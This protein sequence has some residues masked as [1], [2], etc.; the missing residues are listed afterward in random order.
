LTHKYGY[1]PDAAE[2][3]V[4]YIQDNRKEL[5]I[6]ATYYTDEKTRKAFPE[7]REGLRQK[8]GADLKPGFGQM[9][10]TAQVQASNRLKAVAQQDIVVAFQLMARS[11]PVTKVAL[12]GQRRIRQVLVGLG[13]SV[14]ITNTRA[15]YDMEFRNDDKVYH[16]VGWHGTGIY[17]HEKSVL[18]F[19]DESV[20]KTRP[21]VTIGIINEDNVTP[22]NQERVVSDILEY[23]KENE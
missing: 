23:I 18:E 10:V 21:V 17:G 13:F 3:A 2:A 19:I 14:T 8:V 6:P 11:T 12:E 9:P 20:S 15:F 22:A 1:T 16:L 4:K 5:G 7:F